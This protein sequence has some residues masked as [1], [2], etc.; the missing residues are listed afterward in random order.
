MTGAFSKTRSGEAAAESE[1]SRGAAVHSAARATIDTILQSSAVELFH[2][3]G[4]AVAPLVP[5]AVGTQ[6]RFYDWVGVIGFDTE[7]LNGNLTLSVPTGILQSRDPGLNPGDEVS[8]QADWVRELAN[9]LLGRVKNRL[10]KFQ[11][12]LRTRL[13]TSMSGAALELHKRRTPSEMLYRFRALRGDILVV[14]DAPL[15]KAILV[16]SG[17]LQIAKEGD[18]ILF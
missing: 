14:V 17:A 12:V 13:P 2:T 10:S 11:V 7:T 8:W 6:Q 3:Q 5:L 16:Y 15:D 1:R 4:I 18:V 9:Q